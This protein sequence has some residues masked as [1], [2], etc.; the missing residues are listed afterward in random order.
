MKLQIIWIIFNALLERTEKHWLDGADFSC[1]PLIASDSLKK[2]HLVKK[3]LQKL[4]LFVPG[5]F[6]IGLDQEAINSPNP[7]HETLRPDFPKFL[8]KRK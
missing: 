3:K 1:L 4:V 6:I 2:N 8:E 5:F 7:R